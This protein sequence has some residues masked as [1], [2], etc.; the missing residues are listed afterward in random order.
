MN[1]SMKYFYIK[2]FHAS[3]DFLVEMNCC[4]IGSQ[5]L[6]FCVYFVKSSLYKIVP[7]KLK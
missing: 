1:M 3:R 5:Y 6:Y 2:G 7:Q 4:E